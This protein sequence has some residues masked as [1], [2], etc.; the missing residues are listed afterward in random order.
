MYQSFLQLHNSI[1]VL[2]VFTF[3]KNISHTVKSR[4]NKIVGVKELHWL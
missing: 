3:Y 1:F 4:Y 2:F